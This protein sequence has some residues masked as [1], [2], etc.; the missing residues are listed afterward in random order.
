[1]F[2]TFGALFFV[3]DMIL[4][5]KTDSF[6]QKMNLILAMAWAEELKEE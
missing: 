5:A 2:T 3:S 4:L 1:M 6:L